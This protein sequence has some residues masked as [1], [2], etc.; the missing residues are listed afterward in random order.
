[1]PNRAC[2]GNARGSLEGLAGLDVVADEAYVAANLSNPV[3]YIN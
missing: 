1:M 3:G 2:R